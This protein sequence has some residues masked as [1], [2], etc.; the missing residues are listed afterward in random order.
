[1]ELN[2][3]TEWALLSACNTAAG[4]SNDSEGLSGLA[5][6]FFTLVQNHY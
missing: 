6:S 4:E 3:N 1:M 5:K 2:L